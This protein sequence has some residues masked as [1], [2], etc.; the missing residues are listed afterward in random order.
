MPHPVVVFGALYHAPA[1]VSPDRVGPIE[2]APPV[3]HELV[4]LPES[5]QPQLYDDGAFEHDEHEEEYE[6]HGST[7]GHVSDDGAKVHVPDEHAMFDGAD[8]VPARQRFED[9]PDEHQPQ[10]YDDGLEMTR[11]DGITVSTVSIER[12]ANSP[13]HVHRTAC[14]VLP[15]RT[16]LRTSCTTMST[17]R[18]CRRR[19]CTASMMTARRTTTTSSTSS[20]TSDRSNRRPNPTCT[21]SSSSRSC[22]SHTAARQD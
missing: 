21:T 16:L 12:P 15:R 9:V 3:L 22:N 18:S 17:M 10:L 19:R 1:Q 8:D 14:R 4:P 6:L 7:D 20:G 13:V 11:V 2:P 5:H